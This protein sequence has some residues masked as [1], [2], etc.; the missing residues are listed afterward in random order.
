MA[1]ELVIKLDTSSDGN[2]GKL[3]KTLDNVAKSA[4]KAD[5]ALADLRYA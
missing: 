4:T 3:D 5:N 2:I 1:E